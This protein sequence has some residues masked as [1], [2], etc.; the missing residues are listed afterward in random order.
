MYDFIRN[1]EW[2]DLPKGSERFY[3]L[4]RYAPT[5]LP[6][7]IDRTFSGLWYGAFEANFFQPEGTHDLWFPTGPPTLALWELWEKYKVVPYDASHPDFDPNDSRPLDKWFWPYLCVRVEM[8]GTHTPDPD[9]W[10]D[11]FEVRRVLNTKIVDKPYEEYI[12]Q[13]PTEKNQRS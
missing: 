10:M 13:P 7:P 4:N 2:I 11:G 1:G 9:H 12:S 5:P 3:P 6:P 8:E